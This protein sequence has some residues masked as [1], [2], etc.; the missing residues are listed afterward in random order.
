MKRPLLKTLLWEL[1][2]KNKTRDFLTEKN[3]TWPNKFGTNIETHMSQHRDVAS[4][5]LHFAECT[6]C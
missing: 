2:E 3:L 1:K 6:K 5:I 4:Y